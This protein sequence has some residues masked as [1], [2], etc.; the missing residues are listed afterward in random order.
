MQ[1]RAIFPNCLR[2]IPVMTLVMPSPYV[3][4]PAYDPPEPAWK[5]FSEFKDCVHPRQPAAKGGS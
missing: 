2:Y 4:R 1:A 5:S 3:P